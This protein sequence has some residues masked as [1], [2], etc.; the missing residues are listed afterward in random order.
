[1]SEEVW[2]KDQLYVPKDTIAYQD[3][4]FK[5]PLSL[6]SLG[7]AVKFIQVYSAFFLRGMLY[8]CQ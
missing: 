2:G 4:N 7:F 5:I 3:I 8:F 1:M 6:F